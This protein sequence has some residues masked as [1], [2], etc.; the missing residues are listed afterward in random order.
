MFKLEKVTENTYRV[1]T[2]NQ[3]AALIGW[4]EKQDDGYFGYEESIDRAHGGYWSQEALREIVEKLEELNKDW[5]AQ[6]QV[7]L[8]NK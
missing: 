4:L 8:A 6:A 1:L 7:H 2:D 5:D 3:S